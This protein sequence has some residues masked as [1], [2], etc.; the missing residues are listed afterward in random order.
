MKELK[1]GY[2]V[3]TKFGI[4]QIYEINNKATKWKY[5]YKSTKQDGN[6]CIDLS[7]LKEDDILKASENIIDLIEKGDILLL[8]DL[9]YNKKYKAE[10]ILNG[11]GFK[12]VENYELCGLLNLEY[13]LISNEHIKLLKVLTKEQ[14]ENNAYEVE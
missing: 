14:F 6:N 10:V 5:L 13:E 11:E 12:T 7:F 4:K 3:R 8:L 1:V 2:Y 9:E